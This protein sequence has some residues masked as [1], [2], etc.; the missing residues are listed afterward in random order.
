DPHGVRAEDHRQLVCGDPHPAQGPQV[1][2]VE[3]RGAQP[4]RGPALGPGGR[5]DVADDQ[6][7][8][9]VVGVE[10]GGEGGQHGLNLTPYSS[11]RWGASTAARP[12]GSRGGSRSPDGRGAAATGRTR[13]AAT[14]CA[15]TGTRPAPSRTQG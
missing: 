15:T 1:V 8:E 6:G 5:V 13:A 9:R 11:G 14:V 7:R 3:A 10:P 12:S 4:D 2:V